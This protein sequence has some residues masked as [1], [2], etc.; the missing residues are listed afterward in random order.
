M[1]QVLIWLVDS[2]FRINFGSLVVG[3]TRDR[4]YFNMLNIHVLSWCIKL[5]TL[6]N[7]GLKKMDVLPFIMQDGACNVFSSHKTEKVWMCFT[8]A[9][10]KACRL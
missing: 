9:E 10:K 2:I 4:F 1:T 8:K 6:Q 5:S 3:L 7:C